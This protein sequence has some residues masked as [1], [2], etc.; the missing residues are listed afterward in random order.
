MPKEV[1][2]PKKQEDRE[3]VRTRFK[4]V[5]QTSCLPFGPHPAASIRS[6][7]APEP[8]GWKPDPH[9]ALSKRCA[10]GCCREKPD[11]HWSMEFYDFLNRLLGLSLEPKDLNF[12]QI[13]L[14]GIIVFIAAL[15]MLR[16]ADRRF[17]AKLSAF[18][19]LLGFVLASMLARAINGSAAFFPTLGAGFIIVGIHRAMG[20]LAFHWK[21]FGMLI[22]GQERVLVH[23]G[24]VKEA[25]MRAS[26]IT[27][28]DL[29]EEARLNGEVGKISEI[30]LATMERSGQISVLPK[31]GK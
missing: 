15:I 17:M 4:N 8:S 19:A 14:R 27:E 28:N 3:Y 31:D 29:L 2:N 30:E 10:V 5:G 11:V 6:K 16:L 9:G 25:A 21:W 18:D 26:N 23:A 13:T 24:K 1:R 12:G 20:A 7:D 22:K